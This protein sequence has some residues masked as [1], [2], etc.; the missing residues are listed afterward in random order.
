MP[1]PD[2]TIY[3]TGWCGWCNRA[4][5]LLR[6]RGVDDWKEIDVESLPG[7]WAELTERT[8]GRTVPQIYIGERRIG[9]FDDLAALDRAGELDLLLGK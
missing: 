2:I 9:G 6:A 7:G 5:A 4:K 1:N 3:A 8:G